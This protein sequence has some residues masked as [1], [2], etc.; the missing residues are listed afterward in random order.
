MGTR[1][2]IGVLNTDGSVTAVYCHWDG[3]PEHNGKILM[4]N[5]ITEEKVRELIDL[6]SISSLSECGEPDISNIQ[7]ANTF[8][9]VAEFVYEFGE[10][11]NYLFINGTWFVNDNGAAE[12][13]F[14]NP[15]FDMVEQV[16]EVRETVEA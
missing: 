16:L 6:G 9:N 7:G 1:S 8:P 11:Y 12:Q 3:Y 4:E 2:T 5:Y 15:V 10:K 14:G 13:L